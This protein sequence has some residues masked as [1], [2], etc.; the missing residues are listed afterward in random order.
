MD[1]DHPDFTRPPINIPIEPTGGYGGPCEKLQAVR[2]SNGSIV[3]TWDAT[4]RKVVIQT[5]LSPFAPWIDVVTATNS[6]YVISP[7][8]PFEIFRFREVK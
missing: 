5:T 8:S 3:L 6:P 4:C 2:Q 7:N 1:F